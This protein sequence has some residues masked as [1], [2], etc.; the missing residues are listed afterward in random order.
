MRGGVLLRDEARRREQV[1]NHIIRG[2]AVALVLPPNS[3]A[4]QHG[5]Q[6][7]VAGRL[8]I[9]GTVADEPACRQIQ[10]QLARRLPYQAS[11]RLAAF[12]VEF[13]LRAFTLKSLI[14]MMR[15][16]I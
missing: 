15:T 11:I 6:S 3:G 5:A 9:A 1:V 4:Q 8:D 13:Q 7:A 12:A 2:G 10:I 14:G 16:I